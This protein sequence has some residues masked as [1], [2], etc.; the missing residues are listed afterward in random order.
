[1]NQTMYGLMDPNSND[2]ILI[3]NKDNILHALLPELSDVEFLS[4]QGAQLVKITVESIPDGHIA[5]T[6]A[7]PQLAAL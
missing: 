2:L 5:Q 3:P 7:N 1:M 4:G 6:P